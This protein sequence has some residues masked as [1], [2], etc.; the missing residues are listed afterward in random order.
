MITHSS[1]VLHNIFWLT[2]E[3]L[4]SGV[5]SIALSGFV[6]TRLGLIGYGQFT[7]SLS[8][9]ILFSVIANLGMN[10]VL[11]RAIA[12]QPDD[13]ATLWSS[14]ISAKL[15]LLVLYVGTVIVAG[16]ALGY[17]RPLVLVIGLAGVFQSER[18][19]V[20]TIHGLRAE[21]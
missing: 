20:L 3:P 2:L 12:R 21:D 19:C 11:T 15:V 7:F 18:T 6:A 9:V 13:I 8:F 10:D 14:V 16:Y 1:R 5:V 17:E 4:I